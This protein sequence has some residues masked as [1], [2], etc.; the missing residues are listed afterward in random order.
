MRFFGWAPHLWVV[1]VVSGDGGLRETIVP[2]PSTSGRL[3]IAKVEG[4]QDAPTIGDATADL[5]ISCGNVVRWEREFGALNHMKSLYRA[6]KP[7]GIL[8]IVETRA[9]KD[10][11]F[12]RMVQDATATEDHVIALAE[13]AGFRLADRSELN[14]QSGVARMTLKFVKP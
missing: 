1:E 10:T 4:V 12:R 14:A 7:G 8:G 13:V 3:V 2:A 11:P 9:A 5:V 6:L